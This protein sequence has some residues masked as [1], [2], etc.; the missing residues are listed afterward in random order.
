MIPLRDQELIRQRFA[1]GLKTAVK[2][3][4]FTQRPTPVMVPG[5][6]ECLTCPQ[7]GQ[8]L[9]EIAHLSRLI[10]L[11]IHDRGADRA[12]E[13]RYGI[14]RVPAVVV[15]GVVNRPVTF[16]GIPG[17]GLFPVLLETIVA[18]GSAAPELVP[19]VKRRMKR[20]KRAVRV[21]VFTLPEAPGCTEQA[22]LVVVL[23]LAG[24]HVRAEII[25]IAEFPALAQQLGITAVPAT[26]IDGRIGLPGLTEPELLAGEIVR[27]TEQQTVTARGGLITGAV[28][29]ALTRLPP[30]PQEERGTVRPSGLIIPRR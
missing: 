1:D 12:L 11:R 7:T 14:D 17:G 25:E 13:E 28:N 20:L 8:M 27:A 22:L 21:Q 10:E 9:E 18:A 3:D 16:F 29:D 2:I 26:L 23:A 15:R 19:A 6:E 24:Q 30:P 5:R 4:F